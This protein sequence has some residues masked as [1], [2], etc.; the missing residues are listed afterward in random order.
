MT[1]DKS[2]MSLTPFGCSG[3]DN[4]L[5]AMEG[6]R[7]DRIW[8]A[9]RTVA[10]QGGGV[11]YPLNYNALAASQ[12]QAGDDDVL[13]GGAGDDRIG[14]LRITRETRRWRGNP[15]YSSPANYSGYRAVA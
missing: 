2:E 7:I 10:G 13:Y 6:D 3:I 1:T 5:G 8:S 15:E 12:G 11:D 9:T 14:S 4:L